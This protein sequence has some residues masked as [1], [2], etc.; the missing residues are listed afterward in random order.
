MIKYRMIKEE[1]NKQLLNL[2]NIIL[3]NLKNKDFF[4]P[5]EEEELLNLYDKNYVL[6]YGA[7]NEEKLIAIAGI[8]I[9]GEHLEEIKDILNLKHKKV[10]E[11]R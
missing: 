4:I 3:L 10:A 2:I 9:S 1:D 7:F 11:L 5:F 6:L 8:Y